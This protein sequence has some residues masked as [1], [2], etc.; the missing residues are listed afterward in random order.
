MAT[1]LLSAAGASVGG[2]VGGS[3]LGMASSTLFKT[4]GAI[5]GGLIDQ[6]ILGRGSAPVEA[7]RVERFRLQGASEGAPVPQ[8]WGRMRLGGQLI[9]SSRFKEHVDESRQGG[10]G[11][12]QKVREYSYTI[13]FA[14]AL[15]EGA[16]KRIG[17]VWP[18]A[19]RSRLAIFITG[20][21]AA[22]RRRSQTR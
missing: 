2:A 3:V 1:M 7:G 18:M 17:R 16:I 10:K 8:L 21:T 6:Q 14:V 12:G 9:W 22:A 5:A 4:A 19:T 13:S 20:F 11:G 15:C